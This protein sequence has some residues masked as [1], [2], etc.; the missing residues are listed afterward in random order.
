[1]IPLRAYI[2]AIVFHLVLISTTMSQPADSSRRISAAALQR[3]MF[4]LGDDSLEGRAMGSPGGEKAAAYIAQQL[5]SYGVRPIQSVGGFHQYFPGHGSTPLPSSRLT[6]FSAA[7]TSVLQIQRDYVLYT[8][9]AQTFIPSPVPMIFVGYGIVAP[10]YDY[11]DYQNINVQNA[12]VV[13]LSGEPRSSDTSYFSGNRPTIY[14]SFSLKQKAALARGARG[15]ILIQNP[16]DRTQNRWEEELRQFEFE[17]NRLL[18]SPSENLNVLVH[19][20]VAAR[21]F[22]HSAYSYGH[23]V[24]FDSTV[25][26]KSFPLNISASF[27]G[28]FLER[29]FLTSNILGIVPGSDSVLKNTFV[30]LSAHYDHLGI[31]PAVNGD[32]IYNGVFDNAAGVSSLLELARIFAKKKTGLQRSIVFAFLTGEERGFLGSQYYCINPPVPLHQT[33]ANINI[34]GISL[35][36][37]CRS[38]SGI[39][40]ELSSLGTI[41]D[42]VASAHQLTIEQP[43]D[44]YFRFN[45][46]SKSDQFIFAQAG[47]PSILIAEGLHYASSSFEEGL[48]R[49]VTWSSGTYHS[50]SDDLHQRMNFKAAVQHTEFLYRCISAVVAQS[51]SPQWNTGIPFLQARLRTIAEKK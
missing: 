29:D 22:N 25:S 15:S 23:V 37:E 8:V 7:D 2:T 27:D 41:L 17:E 50:P 43:P 3:H 39:G 48:Q 6:I 33:I 32:S 42:S 38:F 34:D 11:N 49:Y 51:S 1:M 10:E 12:I 28:K 18:Y 35:F 26:M 44:D 47:I 9:G 4:I 30:L 40:S 5:Q 45:Q 19:P 14:S 21:L 24:G 16:N 20:A 31:G 13:F 36:E 46:F